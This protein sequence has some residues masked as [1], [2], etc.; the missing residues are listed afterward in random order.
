MTK[1]LKYFFQPLS[2]YSFFQDG[3]ISLCCNAVTNLF[4]ETVKAKSVR[5]NLRL[6]NP[7]QKGYIKC[8][9]RKSYIKTQNNFFSLTDGTAIALCEFLCQDGKNQKI[10]WVKITVD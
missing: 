8:R 9:R 10:F 7:K 2:G 6:K 3:E 1:I 4:P 5:V